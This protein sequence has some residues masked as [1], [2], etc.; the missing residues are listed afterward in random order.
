MKEIQIKAINKSPK[1]EKFNAKATRVKRMMVEIQKKNLLMV[2]EGKLLIPN[3][4]IRKEAPK[5]RISNLTL[6]NPKT[7]KAKDKEDKNLMKT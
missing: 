7:K 4:E 3:K 5:T 1:M 2:M 6:K